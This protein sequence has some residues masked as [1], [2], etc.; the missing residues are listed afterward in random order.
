MQEDRGAGSALG[1]AKAT[2]LRTNNKA[3]EK[4]Y[5]AKIRK[6]GGTVP[7]K[8]RRAPARR[9]ARASIIPKTT[10][11]VRCPKG[12]RQGRSRGSLF[13]NECRL[14]AAHPKRKRKAN[15]R[16]NPWVRHVKAYAKRHGMTYAEALRYGNPGKD[17]H[18]EDFGEGYGHMMHDSGGVLIDEFYDY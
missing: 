6:L 16:P 17:Y 11:M 18:P 3:V 12:Y 5:A 9:N 8:T 14:N 1:A 10:S 7:R 2:Y 4:E 15:A 13:I